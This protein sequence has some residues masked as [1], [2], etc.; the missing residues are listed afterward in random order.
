MDLPHSEFLLLGSTRASAWA[1]IGLLVVCVVVFEFVAG[2]AV[3]LITGV[4]GLPE[5]VPDP[6][7][8][9]ILVLPVIALRAA[10]MIAIIAGALW[11]RRQSVRSLGVRRRGVALDCLLGPG[12]TGVAFALISIWQVIL[13]AVWPALWEETGENALRIMELVPRLNPSGF[14][15]L[16]LLIGVY[17]ELLFRGFLM[18]RLRRATGSWVLAVLLST[19]LFV[20]LHTLDQEAVVIIPITIL[21]LVFSVVTIWRRSVVPAIVGHW[22]FDLY[23]FLGLYYW[24]GDKWA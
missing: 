12:A 16:A 7:V 10:G 20:S 24:A 6:A 1:D 4:A 3:A 15:L 9:R 22:L 17:E 8:E 23:A 2:V 5:E 18:T 19:A 13:W 21:S 14:A 11:F